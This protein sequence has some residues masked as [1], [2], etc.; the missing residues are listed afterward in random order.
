MAPLQP[1]ATF[2]A[3]EPS[4]LTPAD[5]V[6]FNGFYACQACRRDAHIPIPQGWHQHGDINSRDHFYTMSE[7]YLGDYQF[8]FPLPVADPAQPATYLLVNSVLLCT[9]TVADF[10]LIDT[11]GIVA[12]NIAYAVKVCAED[13]TASLFLRQPHHCWYTLQNSH[14]ELQ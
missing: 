6:I 2:E 8:D 5:E 9:A 13:L 11:D 12:T 4:N 1:L 10:Q 7:K 14:T 3:T